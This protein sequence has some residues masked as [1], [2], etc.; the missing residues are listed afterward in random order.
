MGSEKREPLFFR[1]IDSYFRRHRPCAKGKSCGAGLRPPRSVKVQ[2]SGL[3][4]TSSLHPRC[5]ERR[6]RPRSLGGPALCIRY[7]KDP[8]KPSIREG[9]LHNTFPP[10]PHKAQ[11]SPIPPVIDVD[12]QAKTA[13]EFTSG[14]QKTGCAN[15]VFSVQLPFPVC[16][17]MS[18]TTWVQGFSHSATKIRVDVDHP[19]RMPETHCLI[20]RCNLDLS[21]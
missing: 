12:R 17:S 2:K 6:R 11:V 9:Q 7:G 10:P 21:L 4:M 20:C 3:A 8:Q 18:R 14:S 13:P 16:E 19:T 15:R 5:S 1:P